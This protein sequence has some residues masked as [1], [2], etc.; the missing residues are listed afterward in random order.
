MDIFR[1]RQQRRRLRRPPLVTVRR[2]EVDRAEEAVDPPS[3]D[4]TVG[5]VAISRPMAAEREEVV[6]V[7]ERLIT[8]TVTDPLVELD[9]IRTLTITRILTT[10]ITEG[11]WT[12]GIPGQDPWA[13][14]PSFGKP[15][16]AALVSDFIPVSSGKISAPRIFSKKIGINLK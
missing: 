9:F 7:E 12:G 15:I 6:P 5:T 2:A 11:L 10:R 8:I 4:Q 3:T 1:Q 14:R 16:L 13:I